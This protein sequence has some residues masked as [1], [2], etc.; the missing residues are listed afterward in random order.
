MIPPMNGMSPSSS[1]Q[2]DLS[3]SCRRRTPT[4]RPESPTTNMTRP[5]SSVR[6]S[7]PIAMM[8]MSTTTPTMKRASA[9]H[10]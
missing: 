10:Q 5:M 8:R 7:E 3:V 4:D 6:G 2:P 1:S 9:Y